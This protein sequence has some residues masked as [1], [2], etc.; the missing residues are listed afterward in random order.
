MLSTQEII[1]NKIPVTIIAGFLGAGKTTLLNRILNENHG[2]RIAVLVNDFGDVSIDS[3]LI[4]NI[5]GETISL[6]NGCICCTIRED[7]VDAIMQLT[8]GEV[9]PE[10]IVTETSGVSDPESAAKALVIS[11]KTASKISL[12][13]ITT[14]V[15]A[16][17]VLQLEGVNE[18]L[19]VDQIEAADIVVINKADLVDKEQIAEVRSW[20]HNISQQ[21]RIIEASYGEVPMELI[22]GVEE[23]AHNSL[24]ETDPPRK[25]DH[26]NH[27][28][29][30]DTF[31]S[32]TW[33]EN[34]ALSFQA[35][36]QAFKTLPLSVFRAKGILHLRDVDDKRVIL[37]MVGKRV[38]LNKGETWGDTTP[39]SQIVVIGPRGVVHEQELNDLF[40]SCIASDDVTEEN[41]L[42]E[43]VV[44][45]LRRP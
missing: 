19:A 12:N 40:T 3:Q 32:Y 45:F 42:V 10:Y 33:I 27:A 26:S 18:K 34:Q 20:I 21:A 4:T 23:Y 14:V 1:L 30:S 8:E 41:R 28:N 35:I 15:D 17:Q 9:P 13:C 11:T 36:Y 25:H 6:A 38:S 7:M 39:G 16:E 29:H 2:L 44:A 37:Q 43:A 31:S 22:F 24:N 5:E